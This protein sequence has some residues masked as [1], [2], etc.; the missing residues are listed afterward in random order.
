MVTLLPSG[1]SREAAVSLCCEKVSPVAVLQREGGVLADQR[2]EP[3]DLAGADHLVPAFLVPRPELN[4]IPPIAAKLPGGLD[5]PV[6]TACG[7]DAV[8][9]PAA[10]ENVPPRH[11]RITLQLE[12][13]TIP[14]SAHPC[15]DRP[16]RGGERGGVFI[17]PKTPKINAGRRSVGL[18]DSIRSS[19]QDDL[20]K[21]DGRVLS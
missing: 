16:H 8:P 18:F 10:I 5:R 3:L 20:A 1:R 6:E 15:S 14:R 13:A 11:R 19:S 2:A 21:G 12:T 17:P 9:V 4:D 7:A